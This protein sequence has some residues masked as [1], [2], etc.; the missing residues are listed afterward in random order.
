MLRDTEEGQRK[1]L[2]KTQK[3][4]SLSQE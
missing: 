4:R 3:H 2:R 1:K